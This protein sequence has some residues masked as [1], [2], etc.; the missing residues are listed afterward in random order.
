M[1]PSI[2]T[3]LSTA[4]E[5][6]TLIVGLGKTGLSCARFL[7][8]KGVPI[9]VTDTRM[10][11]PGL[12]TLRTEYPDIALAL[13]GFRPEI[14]ANAEQLI[15]SPGIS[16]NQPLIQQA[17]ARGIPIV[18]DIE[19]FA[20]ALQPNPVPVLA[21]TGSNGK[22]TV[23]SLL[24]AMAQTAGWQ[25][26]V[27]GNLGEP[28][29][30]LLNPKQQ[31]YILELSSFQLETTYT[32]Q[33]AAAVVLNISP[34][35]MD[36]YPSLNA[37]AQA[38]ARIYRGAR[39]SIFN[40]DDRLV[41]AMRGQEPELGFTLHPPTEQDYGLIQCDNEYW[42]AQGTKALLPTTKLKLQ[43]LHNVA[44]ALAALALGSAV[45]LP[46][47]AMLTTLQHYA[48]LPH[49]TQLITT[50]AGVRWYNDSKGTNPGATIAALEGLHP[51]QGTGRAILIAGGD[52]K[53]ADFSALAPIVA[54]T[55]R[56]VILFGRDAPILEQALAGTAELIRVVNL[57]QAVQQAAQVAQ[58]GDHVLLSPA[59]ASFDMFRNYEHRG[60][61]FSEC[62]RSL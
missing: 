11:P 45:G 32:L 28:A 18:G 43:G 46:L 61:V 53:D 38:K 23:V 19:L 52:G 24:G 9:T 62:V 48:G 39:I 59:C 4:Q 40:R 57:A 36:R 49:R 60:E 37:Y 58:F 26:A 6:P 7:A 25:A 35:H 55:C 17:A 8:R 10:Q 41:C 54:R 29:L 27:G 14:F 20:Q 42:L 51:K 34:D 44:N 1:H 56:K 30:D 5:P 12:E 16:I 13:G 15:V 22:S 47:E 50:R 3:G 33:T 2:S 21:V 31:L